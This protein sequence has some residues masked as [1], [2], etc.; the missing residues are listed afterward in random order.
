MNNGKVKYRMMMAFPADYTH[1]RCHF[2][3]PSNYVCPAII[4]SGHLK[5]LGRHREWTH[6]DDMIIDMEADADNG[7]E[8][9]DGEYV[10]HR[11]QRDQSHLDPND[12]CAMRIDPAHRKHN[13]PIAAAPETSDPNSIQKMFCI[14]VE[15]KMGR[16]GSKFNPNH[17][18]AT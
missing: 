17:L 16:K 9:D 1:A 2:S 5:S 6:D 13:R 18:T 8:D 7:D 12:V 3:V 14:Q 15:L 4:G 10:D 11:V